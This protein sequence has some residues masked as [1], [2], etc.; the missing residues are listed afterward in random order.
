[1]IENYIFAYHWHYFPYYFLLLDDFASSWVLWSC[2]SR[3]LSTDI[4]NEDHRKHE[5]ILFYNSTK[6][7]VDT[8][9]HIG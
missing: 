8:V 3:Y 5:I 4:S 2:T 1:M 7:G 9:G 6:A